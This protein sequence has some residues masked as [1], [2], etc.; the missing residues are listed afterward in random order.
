MT[1]SNGHKTSSAVITDYQSL[2]RSTTLPIWQIMFSF[3]ALLNVQHDAMGIWPLLCN[4]TVLGMWHDGNS[5]SVPSTWSSTVFLSL[6]LSFIYSCIGL[7]E[8]LCWRL[9]LPAR[10]VSKKKLCLIP[11]FKPY[12]YNT[13]LEFGCC[14]LLLLI[15]KDLNHQMRILSGF[16]NY[17]CCLH[18][19]VFSDWSSATRSPLEGFYTNFAADLN[20]WSRI[21][22]REFLSQF[23]LG[24][25]KSFPSAAGLALGGKS[26]LFL[27]W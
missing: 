22:D 20:S 19:S 8:R 25:T 7:M 11:V 21:T 10:T 18:W 24:I 12:S 27:G 26:P 15:R 2:V 23:K 6:Q 13:L 14:Q 1:T 16:V 3:R 9:F 17:F 4:R 5:V